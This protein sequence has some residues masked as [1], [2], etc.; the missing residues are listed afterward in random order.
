M[1][2]SFSF[3]LVDEPWIPCVREDKVTVELSLLGVFAQAHQL[4][5]L[6]GDSPLVTAA[7]LRF[8][9]ALAHRVYGPHD[10]EEWVRLWEMERWDVQPLEEYL[11][12]W[13]HRFDLFDAAHPFYQADDERV[14]P[15]SVISLSHDRASGNNA[16]L[17]DHHTESTGE[18]LS[19][20]QAARTLIAAQAYGLAGLS[21]IK[22]NFTDGASAGGILFLVE[23]DSLRETMLLNM[24]SYPPDTNQ[25]KVQT[26]KDK[27]AW[28][29]DNA[30]LP[31]RTNP[32]GYL[33]YLTWQNRRVRLLP[34]RFAGRTVVRNMTMGP[35]LRMDAS[36]LDPMMHYREDKKLGH[37]ALSFREDRVLWRDSASLFG[38]TAN[39][40]TGMRPPATFQWLRWLLE[41]M[42]TP[43]KHRLYRTLALGMSKKQAK[44]FFFRQESLPL[45]LA[46]LTQEE[47]VTYLHTVLSRTETVAFDLVQALRLTGML[48][49]VAEVEDGGWQ[50]QWRGLNRNAKGDINNWI[51]HTGAERNYWASL[52][53][54]FQQLIVS[55]PENA[56]E[57]MAAWH[58]Q[59]RRSALAAFDLAGQ[60]TAN[61]ARSFKAVVRGQGYLQYRLDEALGTK[62]SRSG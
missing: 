36:V 22:Q 28:E 4:R 7:L 48:E 44:V 18:T 56:D 12:I 6:A 37:I 14:K 33:D 41:E 29:M 16:T 23:G 46:Y 43:E 1:T 11:S 58:E 19:P 59:L 35:A 50:K 8:L 39:N 51:D 10:E 17:F 20:A 27:P 2:Q 31:K 38:I 15:K 13:R 42:E 54:P 24:L 55:L 45:P 26:D 40:G 62:G 34:E 60:A 61:D 25:F 49:R 57:A 52:D 53:T 30:Y 32:L 9:L 3:N 21:P 47:L 5:H